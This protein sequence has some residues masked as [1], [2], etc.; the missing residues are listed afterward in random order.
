MEVSVT[1]KNVTNK[2]AHRKKVAI[3]V[4]IILAPTLIL[5]HGEEII[6]NIEYGH[7]SNLQPSKSCQKPSSKNVSNQLIKITLVSIEKH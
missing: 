4:P 3:S 2:E 5:P 1:G 6:A 7:I